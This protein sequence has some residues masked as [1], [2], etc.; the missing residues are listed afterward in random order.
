MGGRAIR[1]AARCGPAVAVLACLAALP[2]GA[3][4]APLE[5]GAGRADTTPQTGYF[6]MGW[7]RSDSVGRG[8]HTRLFNRALVLERGKRKVALVAS[9]LGAVP[10]G[11]VVDAAER[12]RGRGFSQEDII[13]STSHTHGAPAG[14][15]NYPAFNTVAPTDETPTEFRVGRPADPRLYTFMVKQL[16]TAIRRADRDREPAVAGWGSTRLLGLTDNRSIE[17]HLANHGIEREYGEGHVGLDP[18]GYGHTIDPRV[19]VL[20]VDKLIGGER[21]PIG[22]W[23]TFANHGTVNRPLFQYYNGDHHGSTNRLVEARIRR[24]G[25]MAPSQE[26]VNAYGNADEGDISSGLH[27]SG[28]AAAEA[29]GRRQTGTMLRAWRLA[30]RD[31]SRTPALDLRWTR[32]C[33]CGQQTSAGRIDDRPVVG[34]PFLTGSEENRGPLFDETGQH[35]EGRRNPVGLGPQGHKVP[36]VT[37]FKGQAFP[38]AVPLTTMRIDDRLIATVPGEMT[39][40]MGR[41]LRRTVLA[42]AGRGV[43]RVVISGLANDFLQYFATPEEYDRQHYEGGSTLFGR[44]A[45]VFVAEHLARLAGRMA[46]GRQAPDP[47]PFD[48]RNGVRDDA[49]PYPL[50]ATS[51]ER[52]AGTLHTRRLE[53]ARL[54][55]LGGARG[56]DRPLDRPFIHVQRR[57][58]GRWRTHTDDLGLEIVWSVLDP[59]GSGHTKYRAQWE[60]SLDVPLGRYR[61]LVTA[62]RYNL[63]SLPFSLRA[64]KKLSPEVVRSSPGRAVVALGYPRPARNRDFTHRPR[65]A[66][67]PQIDLEPGADGVR[68]ETRRSSAV[69]HGPPGTEVRIGRGDARDR[70]GNRNGRGLTLEL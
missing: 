34:L 15:F 46:E 65:W 36:A 9:D 62:N 37:D 61:L 43:S 59:D 19:D 54:R 50:G 5:A 13:V 12:L 48:P 56:R 42:S 49:E 33:F 68:V 16:A 8:V 51:G 24:T 22:M 26:V 18:Q 10:N 25:D 39:A 1:H 35:Y 4:G 20:R 63:R 45:S 66:S 11:M 60:P 3:A 69:V 23:S 17:A 30:G 38:N 14:Y 27:R 55:W 53:H 47:Y 67:R 2:A 31:L 64:S 7:V 70:H 52:L 28:P 32:V 29:V 44:A 6:F 58:D 57:A 41:R 40:D 21:V